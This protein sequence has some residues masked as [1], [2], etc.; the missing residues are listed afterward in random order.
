MVSK[1]YED[2]YKN[3]KQKIIVL[4]QEKNAKKTATLKEPFFVYQ[5]N[6]RFEFGIDKYPR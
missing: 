6:L 2:T 1:W 4:N 5:N 3:G